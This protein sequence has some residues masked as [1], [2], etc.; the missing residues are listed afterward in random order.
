MDNGVLGQDGAPVVLAVDLVRR[1]EPG[2]V[3]THP[4]LLEVGRVEETT[5]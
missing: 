5:L 2:I 1:F 4:L 3:T